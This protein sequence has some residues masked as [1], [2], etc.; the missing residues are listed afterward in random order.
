MK[1]IYLDHAATSPV[2]PDVVAAML[3]IW[4]EDFGNPSSVHQWGQAARHHIEDARIKVATLLNAQPKE[5]IFTGCGTESD[6]MALR[7]V[8]M[9]ARQ[10]G[11]GNHLITSA[12]EHSAILDTAKQL[13]DLYDF[14]VTI[15]D[16]DEFGR[17]RVDDV[18]A[19]IIEDDT[20][21]ISIMAANNEIG[22][23]QPIAEIGRIARQYGIPFHTDAVQAIS[24]TAWD[25]ATMPI[26]LLS[27]APHKFNGPKGIGI[28]Y[29]RDGVELTP[30]MTGGGQE[31]GLRP[32]TENVA[33]AVGA[34]KALEIAQTNR[35]ENV[36][37]YTHLR[38]MLING[39]LDA[40]DDG[41]MLTGHR[42][43]RL[44]FTAS[45]AL[46][47]LSGNDLLMHLDMAG[48]AASSGSAC[49]VGNAKPSRI[50]AA[51]GLDESWTKGGLRLSVGRGVTESD[52]VYAVDKVVETVKRLQS[53][54]LKYA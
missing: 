39:I 51:L 1:S 27:I 47:H 49:S 19:A 52:I 44:P 42:T 20:A 36:K 31:S 4:T 5:I 30:F 16:V 40:L 22:T 8:M 46:Q 32:G 14:D 17:V 41:V 10:S 35:A 34:A 33:F 53:L 43:E 48:I 26:D 6:N 37:H 3:P 38:D 23:L 21:L 29:V 45:F 15:L 2:H 50:L 13:R 18:L 54:A 9:A 11:V 28:L 12:V 25:M 7:G 24:T